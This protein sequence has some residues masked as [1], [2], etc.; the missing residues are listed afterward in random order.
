MQEKPVPTDPFSPIEKQPPQKMGGRPH[1]CLIALVLAV[2]LG[3]PL[4]VGY[5]WMES[6]ALRKFD[7]TSQV[8]TVLGI[9]YAVILLV[10]SVPVVVWLRDERFALWRG[11]ALALALAGGYAAVSGAILSIDLALPWPGLPGVTLPVVSLAYGLAVLAAGRRRFLHRPDTGPVMQGIGLGLLLSIVWVTAGTLGT[12]V[13]TLTAVLEAA[14]TGLVGAVLLASL[15]FYD[16]DMV[17]RR[18]F[19]SAMLAGAVFLALKAGLLVV[20]GYWLQGRQVSLALMPAGFVAGVLLTL[21]DPEDKSLRAW[22]TAFFFFFVVLLVPFAWTE[23]FEGEWMA[24]DM[25]RAWEPAVPVAVIGAG[26]LGAVMLSAQGWLSRA[27][28]NRVVAGGFG[29]VAAAVFVVVY[30]AYGQPGLQPDVF[31]VVMAEQTDTGFTRDIE[32]R[33][34]RVAAVYETLV[35]QALSSQADLRGFL[36]ERGVTYTPYYLVSGIEV[37]GTRLLRYRIAARPDVARILDSPHA[38]PLPSY[39]RPVEVD[40]NN[41]APAV[42]LAWGVDQMDAELVWDRFDDTGQGIV[43]GHADTGVDWTHPALRSRYAGAA[44]AHDYTWFDPWYGTAVPGDDRGHGTQ[45]LGIILGQDGIG[46]APGAQ[47]IACRNL[48]RNLGNPAY[49]LDCMQF[50]FAP[51]PHDGDPFTGGD[52]SRGA[53]IT[54]NSWGCP[55]E[56]GCDGLT[57]AIAVQHLR[58]AGQMFV[59]SAGN[60]GPECSTVWEPASADDAF[61]VGAVG[62]SQEIARFSS[63]GPVLI[64][65]S[66]RVKPD[67]VA[68]GMDIYSSSLEGYDEASGTSM[69]GP[70]VSGLVALL[71]SANPALIGD[72]D[73]TEQIII[74]TAHPIAA[75]GLCGGGTVMLNNVYGHGFVDALDAVQAVVDMAGE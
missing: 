20:R 72:I 52:P 31:F 27:A 17:S 59:A 32:D 10:P 47:W 18:P 44:G 45:T 61:S 57:L 46:V 42:S 68:P 63:R 24:D 40:R 11:L 69:A 29:L 51:H 37:E 43:V 48:G 55:P 41:A 15:F 19:W 50:L 26:L 39:V 35:T 67:V 75:P 23:G 9:A 3:V 62:V 6:L 53:H 13:E 7:P 14:G 70:H 21:G 5:L 56:E 25:R 60:D 30:V 58:N 64:D 4:L 36:D 71:W 28:R 33:G 38:R 73:T 12:P 66:G 22:W 2:S 34:E 16:R 65:G 1:G 8:H 49:Y 74:E 54:N